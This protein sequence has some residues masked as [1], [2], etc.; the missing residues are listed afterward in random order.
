MNELKHHGRKGQHWGIRN[1]SPYPLSRQKGGSVQYRSRK[2]TYTKSRVFKNSNNNKRHFDKKISKGTELQTLTRDPDRLKDTD[3]FY[4]SYHKLDKAYYKSVFNKPVKENGKK[5]YKMNATTV[6]KNDIK[7][8]SVDSVNEAFKHLYQTDQEFYKFCTDPHRL[9]KYLMN[10]PWRSVALRGDANRGMAFIVNNAR[11][12]GKTVANKKDL[13]GMCAMFVTTMAN[14]GT[15][16]KGNKATESKNRVVADDVF[17]QRT[18]LFNQL[19]KSGYGAML[20]RYNAI[21]FTDRTR[22]PVVVFDMSAVVP[23]DVRETT[24]SEVRQ[25]KRIGGGSVPVVAVKRLFDSILNE[26]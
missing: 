4:A 8:A 20:D 23:K 26:D 24:I 5:V 15:I 10:T 17:K 7:V 25:A 6:A 22:A 16:Y 3:M 19:K 21:D 1:G 9:S 18:K 12:G 11:N 13:E 14:D 2:K